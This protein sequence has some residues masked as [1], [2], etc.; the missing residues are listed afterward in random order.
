[1]DFAVGVY[2]SGC[3]DDFFEFSAPPTRVIYVFPVRVLKH[4]GL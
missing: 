2:Q 3:H 4:N 1:M